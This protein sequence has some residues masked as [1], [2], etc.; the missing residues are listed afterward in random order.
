[1][2][3]RVI[4]IRRLWLLLM[5]G[6]LLLGTTPAWALITGGYGNDPIQDHQWPDG[7]VDVANLKTRVGWWEGPPFGGGEYHFLYRGN[8]QALNDALTLLSKI[9]APAVEVEVHSG[10]HDDFWLQIDSRALDKDPNQQKRDP[11]IDFEFVI[12]TPRNYH[13]LYNHPQATISA[14]QPNFHKPLPA[15]QFIV[16]VGGGQIDWKDVKV[17]DNV[18]LTDH[19]SKNKDAKTAEV[20]G[21]VYNVI[22]S[23]P[24]IGATVSVVQRDEKGVNHTVTTAISDTLGHYQ[25][26]DVP[27]GTNNVQVSADG[28]AAR[29]LGWIQFEAGAT[30]KLVTY[31]SPVVKVEGIVKNENG[32]PVEG[33]KVRPFTILG[34]DGLG[35]AMP[36]RPEA[37]TDDQ[38][39]FTLQVPEGAVYLSCHKSAMHQREFLKLYNVPIK[40]LELTMEGTTKVSIRLLDNQGQPVSGR[41]VSLEP[42]GEPIGKWGG[43]SNTDDKGEVTFEG[44]PPGDYVIM[45][46]GPNAKE[47]QALQVKGTKPIEVSVKLK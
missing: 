29:D 40:N 31:L 19:R 25:L 5:F 37:T 17:P 28:L 24:I 41:V 26:K 35:Y 42:K 39:K 3:R 13:H 43:S 16:Y 21:R 4:G 20:A 30:Q 23:K 47:T 15:P 18:K 8:A 38:G 9:N 45:P 44:V 6:F 11:R 36:D 34:I 27:P 12:W 14:D 10:P 7:A 22:T 33:A 1:M 32:Q 46:D 2:L